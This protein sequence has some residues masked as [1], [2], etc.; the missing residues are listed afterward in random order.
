VALRQRKG[1]DRQP[2][3]THTGHTGEHY[4]VAPTFRKEAP[5]L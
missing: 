2:R 4:T 5:E 3:L 1:F